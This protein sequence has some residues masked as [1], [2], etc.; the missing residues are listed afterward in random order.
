MI[1]LIPLSIHQKGADVTWQLLQER[2]EAAYI[3]HAG[4]T[5]REEHD[6]YISSMPYRAW[7]IIENEAGE[8]VGAVYLT[9]RNEIGIAILKDYQHNGYATEAIKAVMDRYAPLS[10]IPGARQ[11]HYVA[12]VAP[13]NIA[14]QKLFQKLGARLVQFTYK[15]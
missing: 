14:S 15:L 13:T 7:E 8:P 5:A 1:R 2:P 3:S 12:N 6:R 10:A 4:N 9:N 11:A